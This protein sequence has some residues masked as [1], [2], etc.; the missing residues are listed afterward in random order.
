[1]ICFAAQ[2]GWSWSTGQT[3]RASDSAAW[4]KRGR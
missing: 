3:E 2:A 4:W 1:M